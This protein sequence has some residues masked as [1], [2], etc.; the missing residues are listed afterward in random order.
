MFEYLMPL[1][2]MPD[3][4]EHAA[5]P[6]LSHDGGAADRVRQAARRALGHLRVRLQLGRCEPQLPVP[7]VRRAGPRVE[8]RARRRS[9][10]RALR[11]GARADGRSRGSV[12]QPAAPRRRRARRTIRPV[13]GDRLHAC[14][15]APRAGERRRALLHGASP[16]HDPALARARA[17]RAADAEALRVGPAVQGNPAAAAGAHPEGRSV[18]SHPAEL[19]AIR[20]IAGGPEAPVRVLSSPTRR[21]RKCSCCPTAATTSWS[22]TRAAAA[23]AGRTS[24]SPAGAKTAPATTGARSATSATWRA[25]TSGRPR[26]SRRASAPA[27]YEAIF[28]EARAEFRRRD[29]DLEAHTEIVVSPED[30]IELR[31][32]RIT[33]RRDPAHDRGHQLRRGGARA[34]GR[35]RAASGVLQSLRA[36]RDRRRS[37]RRSCARADRARTTSGALDV[38]PHGRPR[39]GVA[40]RFLRD[41]PHGVHRPRANGRRSAGDDGA[42]RLSG[43]QGRC[44]I[45]SSRS[46]IG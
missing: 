26:I 25:G 44:S 30:D 43:A 35:G 32:V 42:G 4:R 1:L 3:V 41:G 33:N 2:V 20:A 19:S 31:R 15:P 40:R 36:D 39:G 5:R 12:R 6:D 13:R 18:Y 28:S 34:P 14:A 7:R 45:R 10:H 11:V 23:A 27:H 29:S 16:G 46:A 38:P 22:R 37:A 8:A 17:A 24:P 9:R 21:C